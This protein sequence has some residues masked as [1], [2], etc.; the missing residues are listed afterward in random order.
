VVVATRAARTSR[1]RTAAQFA[2]NEAQERDKVDRR[3][4]REKAYHDVY[5][6]SKW[7]ETALELYAERALWGSDHPLPYTKWRLDQ[8]EG[9]RHHRHHHVTAPTKGHLVSPS[10]QA[11][12]HAEEAGARHHVLAT[13]QRNTHAGRYRGTAPHD[14]QHATRCDTH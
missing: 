11:P 9:Y 5:E 10:L 7:F 13:L 14:T 2:V 12:A 8:V 3:K 4:C 6:E 1:L